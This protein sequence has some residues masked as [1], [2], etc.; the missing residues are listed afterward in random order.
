MNRTRACKHTHS[1][2]WGSSTARGRAGAL[3]GWAPQCS[4]P[5]TGPQAGARDRCAKTVRA[6]WNGWILWQRTWLWNQALGEACRKCR[7]EKQKRDEISGSQTWVRVCIA[8]GCGKVLLK[9][10]L[11]PHSQGREEGEKESVCVGAGGPGLALIHFQVI[12]MWFKAQLGL[13]L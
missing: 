5:R 13:L 11:I 3:P 12:L 2:L 6:L 1:A 7:R 9:Q 10:S 4:S 8:A